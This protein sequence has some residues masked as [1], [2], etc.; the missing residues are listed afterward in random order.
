MGQ[1]ARVDFSLPLGSMQES[2]TVEG[3]PA[4][5]PTADVSLGASIAREQAPKP[6]VL[7]PA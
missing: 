6:V 3:E 5:P 2:I 4:M 1:P 7:P